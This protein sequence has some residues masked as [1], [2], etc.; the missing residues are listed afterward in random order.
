MKEKVQTLNQSSVIMAQADDLVFSCMASF[1]CY[2]TQ[3]MIKKNSLILP[4]AISLINHY[5][6]I[7]KASFKGHKFSFTKEEINQLIMT[8][9][10]IPLQI[11][12]VQ[13]YFYTSRLNEGV[14]LMETCYNYLK[15]ITTNDDSNRLRSISIW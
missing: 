7:E 1:E 9:A 12:C 13:L 3:E 5:K 10:V 14:A 4:N 6:D 2:D 15:Y 11:G 8:C